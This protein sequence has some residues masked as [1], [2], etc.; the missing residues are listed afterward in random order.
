MNTNKYPSTCT[1]NLA[2]DTD[3]NKY[4]KNE[5]LDK[6]NTNTSTYTSTCTN[7]VVPDTSP[8]TFANPSC[9][10]SSMSVNDGVG[11]NKINLSY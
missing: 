6:T 5:A 9:D 11:K 3:A 2:L 1:N 7:N 4:D 10:A 8:N